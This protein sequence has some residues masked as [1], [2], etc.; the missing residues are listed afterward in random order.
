MKIPSGTIVDFDFEGLELNFSFNGWKKLCEQAIADDLLAFNYKLA[1]ATGAGS[2]SDYDEA[3]VKMEKEILI[4]LLDKPDSLNEMLAKGRRLDNRRGYDV[5]KTM[6]H[7][8]DILSNRHKGI[9]YELT[10]DKAFIIKYYDTKCSLFGFLEKKG[11]LKSTAI[12]PI[13]DVKYLRSGFNKKSCRYII[14]VK[15]K[16]NNILIANGVLLIGPL[17]KPTNQ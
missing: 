8:L 6:I 14:F 9:E 1:V 17:N 3:V 15:T 4:L 5:E 7:V 2:Q 10:S 12:I 16:K 13:K 11:P